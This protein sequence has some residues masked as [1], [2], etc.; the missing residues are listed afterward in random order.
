MLYSAAFKNWKDMNKMNSKILVFI[1]FSSLISENS[2][3]KTT[4]FA[5]NSYRKVN[6]RLKIVSKKGYYLVFLKVGYRNNL[7]KLKATLNIYLVFLKV[8]CIFV[9]K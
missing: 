9:K 1:G 8:V 5:E 6:R 7:V 3:R 4:D 2:Y